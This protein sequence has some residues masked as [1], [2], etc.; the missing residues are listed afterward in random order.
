MHRIAFVAVAATLAAAAP[1]RA[2]SRAWTAAK[3]VLPAGLK[4]VVGANVAELRKTQSFKKWW[5]RVVAQRDGTGELAKID[6]QCGF[7]IVDKIDSIVIGGD[8]AGEIVG[9]IAVDANAKQLECMKK[10]AKLQWLAKDVAAFTTGDSDKLTAGGIAD[11]KALAAA[12]ARVKTGASAWAIV[13]KPELG[14]PS[15]LAYGNATLASGTVNL[16]LHL[17]LDSAPTATA[18]AM[19]AS[20]QLAEMRKTKGSLPMAEAEPFVKTLAITASGSEI[21]VTT[22]APEAAIG[23]LVDAL[24]KQ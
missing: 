5:P 1:A 22:S 3:K 23:P 21:V 24:D 19:V 6:K 11:D 18:L 2:D 7:A 12:L 13:V 17:V 14:I 15:T 16:E 20:T 4:G 8:S 10:T 9:V